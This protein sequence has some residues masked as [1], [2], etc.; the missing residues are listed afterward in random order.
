MALK[1]ITLQSISALSLG[2]IFAAPSDSILVLSNPLWR[3]FFICVQGFPFFT[4]SAIV[5]LV[6]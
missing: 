1:P 5:S 3:V 6:L 4:F 2:E